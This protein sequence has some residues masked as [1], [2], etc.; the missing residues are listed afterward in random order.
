MYL[1]F[2]KLSSILKYR[3][4]GDGDLLWSLEKAKKMQITDQIRFKQN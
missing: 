4:R 3:P 2:V 1:F